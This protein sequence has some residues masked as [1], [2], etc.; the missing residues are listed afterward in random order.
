[1]KLKRQAPV[2]WLG[3]YVGGGRVRPYVIAGS[4]IVAI[5]GFLGYAVWYECRHPCLESRTVHTTC[6][7]Y[8]FCLAYDAQGLCSAHM[9]MPEHECDQVECLKREGVP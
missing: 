1:M 3:K 8:Y 9:L 4:A 7:G 6:P 2:L 5:L